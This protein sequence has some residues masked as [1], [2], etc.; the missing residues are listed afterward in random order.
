LIQLIRKLLHTQYSQEA[1]FGFAADP[2]R[3]QGGAFS[4]REVG[5]QCGIADKL[6]PAVL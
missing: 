5:F 1:G 3:F 4:V 2:V 6:L